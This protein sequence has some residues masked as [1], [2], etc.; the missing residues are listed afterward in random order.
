MN[1]L[2]TNLR[3]FPQA[4]NDA[5][6]NNKLANRVEQINSKSD[7]TATKKNIGDAVAS[8]DAAAMKAV[9]EKGVGEKS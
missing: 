2:G 9:I 6:Y 8:G 4:I 1:K 5:Q 7:I 3:D